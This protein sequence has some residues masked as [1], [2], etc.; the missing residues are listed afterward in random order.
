MKEFEI[1]NFDGNVIECIRAKDE[2]Q[3]LCIYLMNHE[4]LNDMMLW[5]GG[6]RGNWKLAEYDTEDEYI[7]ARLR[8]TI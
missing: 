4:E 1:I 3:A 6:W 5:Y 2:R 7:Y 8:I